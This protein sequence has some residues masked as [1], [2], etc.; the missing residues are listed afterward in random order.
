M[1]RNHLMLLCAALVPNTAYALRARVVLPLHRRP[2]A[3]LM[4]AGAP[5]IFPALEAIKCDGRRAVILIY[6][7]DT[8]ARVKGA[9]RLFEDSADDYARRGC[10]LCAVRAQT[11][12][13]TEDI[14]PSISFVD[15]LAEMVELR[16]GIGLDISLDPV[17]W[18]PRVYLVDPNGSVRAFGESVRMDD[19]WA[20]ITTALHAVAEDPS[21]PKQQTAEEVLE[22][23]EADQQR[24]TQAYME[25]SEWA[26]VLKDDESLRQ[27]TRG[28]FDGWG[29]GPSDRALTAAELKMLPASGAPPLTSKDGATKAPD[30]YIIA[31]QRAEAKAADKERELG[32]KAVT[33]SSSSSGGGGG[34]DGGTG[35]GDGGGRGLGG[36]GGTRDIVEPA[37]NPRPGS[38]AAAAAQMLDGL[39]GRVGSAPSS[40]PPPPAAAA[41]EPSQSAGGPPPPPPVDSTTIE[42]AKLLALGLSRSSTSADTR[43][44]LRLLRELEA[45]VA[46]LEAEG[47]LPDAEVLSSLKERIEAGWATAPAEERAKRDAEVAAAARADEG[48]GGRLSYEDFAAAMADLVPEVEFDP[49]KWRLSFGPDRKNKKGKGKR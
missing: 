15:G 8:A 38:P 22:L 41:G 2:S 14:Y 34:S 11:L 40:S 17:A 7:S 29:D 32:G 13:G 42:R 5:A 49:S 36:G 46:E 48:D 9:L 21:A 25:N 12:Y 35:G 47:C 43:R 37:F 24:R 23:Y 44:R 33:G 30:W 6:Q 27:P 39:L 1:A 45:T 16:R 28:W 20:I 26:D 10:K 3:L 18:G 4:S 19:V 31:K